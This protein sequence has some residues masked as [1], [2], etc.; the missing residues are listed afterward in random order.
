MKKQKKPV[1]F[2]NEEE[3]FEFWSK[4]DSVD[5]IDRRT[6]GRG[7]FPNLKPSSKVISLRL[8][9]PLLE[10]VK[11]K[12]H[13]ARVPYQSLIKILIAKGVHGHI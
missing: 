9:A 5:Y 3:E 8:P 6:I 12:A 13:K 4:A 1:H 11:V 10:R 2:K 7:H